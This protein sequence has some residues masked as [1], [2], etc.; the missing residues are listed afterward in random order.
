MPRGD[1]FLNCNYLGYVFKHI[2][3]IFHFYIMT[4]VAIH[5]NVL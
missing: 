3:P 1:Y 2:L 4:R 5:V